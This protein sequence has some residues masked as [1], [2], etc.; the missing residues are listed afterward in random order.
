MNKG[1]DKGIQE[2]GEYKCRHID[3]KIEDERS[4]YSVASCCDPPKMIHVADRIFIPSTIEG[5]SP[6]ACALKSPSITRSSCYG[7]CLMKV[8]S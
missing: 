2:A 5:L 7:N 1:E 6:L 8:S 4:C 3:Y